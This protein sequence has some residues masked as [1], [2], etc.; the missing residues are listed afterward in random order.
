VVNPPSPETFTR[1]PEH[2]SA[3]ERSRSATWPLALALVVGLTIGFA[4]GYGT[5]MRERPAPTVS[6]PAPGG[7]PAPAGR[8]FTESAVN[9]AP[10]AA[11]PPAKPKAAAPPAPTPALPQKSEVR[12]TTSTSESGGRLLVR[13]TPAGARVFVDGKDQGRT[14]AVVRDLAHGSHR[15][16]LTH[17]G[18]STEERGIVIT[19]SRPSQSLTI[20]LQRASNI[21]QARTPSA[22]PVSA[23]RFSGELS[24][25][26]R[27][28]GA[29]V[30]LDNKIVGTTPLSIPGVAAGSHAIRLERDGYRRWTSAIRVVAN[31][32]NRVTASLEK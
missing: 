30:F 4:G 25:I 32:Q 6:A 28:A 8:E 31:E 27:P 10:K 5:G 9:E 20:P 21:A 16:R 15:V 19:T 23:S 18:Y 24:V 22:T 12:R 13:S 14:P 29:S 7:T 17:D 3:L 1:E 2:L 26:S 11:A